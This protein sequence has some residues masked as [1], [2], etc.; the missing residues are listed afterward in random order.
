MMVFS[1]PH[2]PPDVVV[3]SVP[4]CACNKIIIF[5]AQLSF[6]FYRTVHGKRQVFGRPQIILILH[7]NVKI[8]INLQTVESVYLFIMKS[9]FTFRKLKHLIYFP[10]KVLLIYKIIC[11]RAESKMFTQIMITYIYLFLFCFLYDLWHTA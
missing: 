8:L 5:I 3:C 2:W 4:V 7:L 1:Y 10:W 9:I 6:S 11:Y